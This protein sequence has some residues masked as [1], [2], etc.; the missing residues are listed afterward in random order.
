MCVRSFVLSSVLLR[1]FQLNFSV[2]FIFFFLLPDLCLA[3]LLPVQ[4][5]QQPASRQQQ[6]DLQLATTKLH[7]LRNIL[8][9]SVCVVVVVVVAVPAVVIWPLHKVILFGHLL[10]YYY[11]I[12]FSAEMLSNIHKTCFS[13]YSA[14]FFCS[15]ALPF[16]ANRTVL[17][18]C[19]CCCCYCKLQLNTFYYVWGMNNRTASNKQ[20]RQH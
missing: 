7:Y 11:T 5:K 20:T 3:V 2:L 10:F 1:R 4:P 6:K 16:F 17:F 19:C 12:F 15:L 14:V 13:F 9:F 8:L 18:C